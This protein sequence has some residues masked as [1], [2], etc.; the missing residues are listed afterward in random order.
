VSF[1]DHCIKQDQL[2][3]VCI[4]SMRGGCVL[5]IARILRGRR[6]R[7]MASVK[8]SFPK[9]CVRDAKIRAKRYCNVCVW[10]YRCLELGEV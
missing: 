6:L 3:S 7:L 2:I 5:L 4:R 10:R 1:L 8:S 9:V